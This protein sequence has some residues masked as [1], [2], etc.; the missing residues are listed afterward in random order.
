MQKS[1][2]D[3]NENTIVSKFVVNQKCE[4][5][6]DTKTTIYMSGVN[7]WLSAVASRQPVAKVVPPV[8]KSV[9]GLL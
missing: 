9:L 3:I 2:G 5:G 8:H 4:N 6:N 1:S 7:T